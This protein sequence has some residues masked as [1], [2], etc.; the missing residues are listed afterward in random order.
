M[1]HFGLAFQYLITKNIKIMHKSNRKLQI[2]YKCI[3]ANT[4]VI[5]A[6]HTN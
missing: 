3:K 6:A 1:D 2:V 5:N 4:S